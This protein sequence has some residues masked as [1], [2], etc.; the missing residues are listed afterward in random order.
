MAPRAS[1]PNSYMNPAAASE[2]AV[3]ALSFLASDRVRLEKFL[4]LSGLGPNNLRRA[5]ADPAFLGAVLDHVLADEPLLLAFA[6]EQA[7]PPEDVVRAREALGAPRPA[8]P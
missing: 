3:A 1:N 2:I 4:G 5:A 8:A 6:R 7:K